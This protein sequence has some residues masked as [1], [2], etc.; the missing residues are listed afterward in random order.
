[1]DELTKAFPNVWCPSCDSLQPMVLAPMKAD[2][3]NPDDAADMLCGEC[4]FII[5]DVIRW[6]IEGVAKP[7]PNTCPT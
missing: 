5:C 7:R 2:E 4:H 6:E 3:R 1:M